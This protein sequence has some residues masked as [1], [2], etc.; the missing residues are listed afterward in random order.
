MT[1]IK[2][3]HSE[4]LQDPAYRV[5]YDA[6]DEEF[7]LVQ[8]LIEA[9]VRAGLTQAEL[10]TRME[11][12]QSAVARLESGRVKP[13]ARTLERFAKATGTRLNIRFDPVVPA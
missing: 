5:A 4:W 13:S 11:T 9:R 3:L 1:L 6:L 10:A 12:S 2:E 7:S 8:A